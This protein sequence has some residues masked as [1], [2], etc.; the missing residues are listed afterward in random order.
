MNRCIGLRFGEHNVYNRQIGMSHSSAIALVAEVRLRLRHSKS[1]KCYLYQ[2][3]YQNESQL[4]PFILSPKCASDSDMVRIICINKLRHISAMCLTC[5]V[6]L[7]LRHSKNHLYQQTHGTATLQP[8]ALPA[9]RASDSDILRV[10]CI[11]R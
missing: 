7:R 5:R 3:K 8:C 2:E 6:R 1:D 9:E 11:N 10:I 4:K